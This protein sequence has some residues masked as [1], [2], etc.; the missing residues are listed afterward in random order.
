MTERRNTRARPYPYSTAFYGWG[1]SPLWYGSVSQLCASAW[2]GWGYVPLDL[3]GVLVRE[4]RAIWLAVARWGPPSGLYRWPFHGP[5]LTHSFIHPCADP[6][7]DGQPSHL[8]ISER[9]ALLSPASCRN[10]VG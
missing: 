7:T 9:G 8:P 2:L 10:L 6:T 3:C 1:P 4:S 5:T